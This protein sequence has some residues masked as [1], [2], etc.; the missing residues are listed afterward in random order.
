MLSQRLGLKNRKFRA[1]MVGLA[2]CG[3][4]HLLSFYQALEK[5]A[6][7]HKRHYICQ[8][9]T[10]YEW[11][12]FLYQHFLYLPCPI[13]FHH[14][15]YLLFLNTQILWPAKVFSFV[16]DIFD[17]PI[18]FGK[19]VRRHFL[20]HAHLLNSL[21]SHPQVK[22][23]KAH[24]SRGKEYPGKDR[25]AEIKNKRRRHDKRASGNHPCLCCLRRSFPVF[26]DKSLPLSK[27]QKKGPCYPIQSSCDKYVD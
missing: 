20:Y 14:F 10:R 12:P 26:K 8:K 7:K 1:A 19:L 16:L 21:Y 5:N 23:D 4:H 18:S 25:L 24:H 9:K 15:S 13:Q 3:K 22:C 11:Y 27:R 2:A 17:D 6:S